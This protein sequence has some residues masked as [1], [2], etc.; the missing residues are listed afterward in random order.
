[1]SCWSFLLSAAYASRSSLNRCC[2]A[3]DFF[4]SA[5][6]CAIQT[7]NVSV[8][9]HTRLLSSLVLTRL[10]RLGE[11]LELVHKAIKVLLALF[12]ACKRLLLQLRT[13]GLEIVKMRRHARG[14]L[15]TLNISSSV[16]VTHMTRAGPPMQS[17]APL[18]YVS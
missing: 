8:H 3:A 17:T 6:F 11:V 1:M 15:L 9:S 4:A 12:P 14:E 7:A 16:G 2:S 18:W 13:V 5:S 10:V